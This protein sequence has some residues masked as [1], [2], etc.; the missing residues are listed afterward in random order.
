MSCMCNINFTPQGAGCLSAVIG[1]VPH[2]LNRRWPKVERFKAN[3]K[4]LGIAFIPAQLKALEALPF[5]Q[6]SRTASL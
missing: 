6:V 5:D 4:A 2:D 3:I 1:N